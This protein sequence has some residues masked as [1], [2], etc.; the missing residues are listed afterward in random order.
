MHIYDVIKKISAEI[1]KICL[2][3]IQNTIQ[4]PIFIVFNTSLLL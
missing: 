1:L 3:L 4:N 2:F